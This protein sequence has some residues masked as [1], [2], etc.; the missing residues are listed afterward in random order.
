MRWI[1]KRN[2]K[3]RKQGHAIVGKF[4]F[5]G[6]DK[7]YGR[8]INCSYS[9]LLRE[10]KMT[11]LLLREQ[12]YMCCYCMRSISFKRHTTI[13]HV[14]PRMT[15]R[16]D[17]NAIIHYLNSSRFMKR[18]VKW[19]EEPPRQRVK[20]PPYPHYCA[21]ENLVVSCDGSIYDLHNPDCQYSRSLHNC[22]NNIRGNK[23]IIPMF[24]LER[25]DRLLI[26]ERDGELTYDE[27]FESTIKAI[28][29]EYDTLKLMR[30]AWASICEYYSVEDVKY[31][32]TDDD[33][34]NLIID[35]SRLSAFDGNLLRRSTFWN[36]LYEYRWFHS[37]FKR[38][39]IKLMLH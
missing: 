3:N 11:H 35:D 22:C 12:G 25:I 8:Y 4:L 28:R 14:L 31:A 15:K 5:R 30:R 26:Y 7:V 9:D 18:Y 21:Y 16:T 27:M 17:D 2:R 39:K 33:L 20:V 29:L 36:L 19:T 1:N 32:I 6:W 13:E 37:Y 10:G 38:K 23:E 34:R 24:F